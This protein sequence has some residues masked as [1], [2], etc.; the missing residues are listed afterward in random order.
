MKG[1]LF[2]EENF[3]LSVYNHKTET[4]RGPE[5]LTKIINA[6]ADAWQ[7]PQIKSVPPYFD[8]LKDLTIDGTY[9]VFRKLDHKAGD[10]P[11]CI[12]FRF[13]IGEI[14]YV[15]EPV[16]IIQPSEF[17]L[18]KDFKA[19][20]NPKNK[21]QVVNFIY[22]YMNS[23]L[24]ANSNEKKYW[25][26]KMFMNPA[27]A[28]FYVKFT[29][30][31]I[32][33]LFDISD[34]D[35]FREGIMK[36]YA[37]EALTGYGLFDVDM[38]RVMH[39]GNLP[40]KAYHKIWD[41]INGKGSAAK[42]PYVFAFDYVLHNN[43]EELKMLDVELFKPFPYFFSELET[44]HISLTYDC[45]CGLDEC[46]FDFKNTHPRWKDIADA[47]VEHALEHRVDGY[48]LINHCRFNYGVMNKNPRLPLPEP[49]K[50][51]ANLLY[52]DR[53]ETKQ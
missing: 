53:K 33:R 21:N 45:A 18:L 15:Q 5:Q 42:N 30:I 49:V 40:H 50:K 7:R 16:H 11:V 41:D 12:K 8:G 10:M 24:P 13:E 43:L 14:A 26:N 36:C 2:T 3:V 17:Y 6:D 23:K 39:Y 38:K 20:P 48:F 52:R 47:L 35:C 37:A 34:Q 31:K 9:A 44:N 19:I 25:Q 29:D 51:Y 4:R 1:I 46:W 28:R 22:R 32:E 27:F